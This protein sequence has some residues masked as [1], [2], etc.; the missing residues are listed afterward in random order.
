MTERMA[1]MQE[2]QRRTSTHVCPGCEGP[3]YCAM[4]D[5]KSASTCWCM[6][7]PPKENKA[8]PL[9]GESCYCKTC[10]TKGG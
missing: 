5:G 8:N 1:V 9:I 10:L 7:L 2:I 3:A 6:S 4:E